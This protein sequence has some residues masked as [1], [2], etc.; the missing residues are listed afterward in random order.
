MRSPRPDRPALVKGSARRSPAGRGPRSCVSAGRL[1]ARWR[2]LVFHA[3]RRRR[4]RPPPMPTRLPTSIL[5]DLL[6]Q[7]PPHA[8]SFRASHFRKFWLRSATMRPGPGL[9]AS[10]PVRYILVV[11]RKKDSLF[12]RPLWTTSPL[13]SGGAVGAGRS[14]VGY[15]YSHRTRS[16]LPT[17]IRKLH[18]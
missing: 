13:L 14:P 15:G 5:S 8:R 6:R 16:F 9:A 10:P 17:S 3:A 18:H 12:A 7:S 2:G 4:R 11:A 1:R